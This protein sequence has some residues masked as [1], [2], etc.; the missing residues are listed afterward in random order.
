[1]RKRYAIARRTRSTRRKS[2]PTRRSKIEFM[3]RENGKML[4]E[5][6]MSMKVI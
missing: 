6:S 4:G 5:S 1:M 3:R 2:R